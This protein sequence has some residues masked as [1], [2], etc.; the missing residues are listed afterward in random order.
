MTPAAQETRGFQDRFRIS[1]KLAMYF[2]TAL[3]VSSCL[4]N[5]AYRTVLYR[6]IQYNTIQHH[7]L[8]ADLVIYPRIFLAQLAH[9]TRDPRNLPSTLDPLQ[10]EITTALAV[11]L[12]TAWDGSFSPFTHS[13]CSLVI[14]NGLLNVY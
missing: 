7:T 1:H 3:L 8:T 6:I 9:F 10:P 14:G 13:Q 4:G 2:K 11:Y 12:S 5:F